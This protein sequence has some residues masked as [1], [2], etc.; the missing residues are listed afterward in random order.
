MRSS[1]SKSEILQRLGAE[2]ARL[3]ATI[4]SID[5]VT[6]VQPGVVG[7]WSVKDVLAH[8]AEW[9]ARMLVWLEAARSGASVAGPEEGLTWSDLAGFNRRIYSAHREEPLEH[10]LAS[11]KA[12]HGRF[13]DMVQAMPA[14]E[15]L[16]RGRYALTAPN[17]L[18]DW[19]VQ[20]AQH[21]AWGSR[22]IREWLARQEGAGSP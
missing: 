21:D 3:E 9:E 1:R 13:M 4:A 8:L 14:D 15:M 2:R 18:Y 10:V 20:Y 7:E 11:F 12:E 22:R 16:E 5:A 6:M 19:L 17:A